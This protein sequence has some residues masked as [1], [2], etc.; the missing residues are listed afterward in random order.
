MEWQNK[1]KPTDRTLDEKVY[2]ILPQADVFL[3]MQE[4]ESTLDSLVQRKRL[5]LQ[6]MIGRSM[7]ISKTL[8]I[9]VSSQVRNQSWQQTEREPGWTLR[10]EG[11]LL[12][13][14]QCDGK[15]RAFS[16][17]VTSVVVDLH[18]ETGDE[19]VEWHE[20]RLPPEQHVEFDGLDVARPG[21][22]KVH[23]KVQIQLKEYPDLF[24]LS[25]QLADIL[26]TTEESKPA[27]VVSLW[28]YIRYHQLQDVDEKRV[29][30]C[31]APLQA[32]FKRDK[33]VLPQ[34]VE[35]LG[36]HLS[37]RE[38][39][40]IEYDIDPT[41]DLSNR[42]L[43]FDV[44]IQVDHALRSELLAMLN[45]WPQCSAMIAHNDNGIVQ[46]VQTLNMLAYQ[47][48]FYREFCENPVE[49]INNWVASQAA[50]LKA[51]YSDR[52]FSEEAVRHSSFYT[53]DLIN[54]ALHLFLGKN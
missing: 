31:N 11:R 12:N 42:D 38:P 25:P 6:D 15:P 20:A 16:S 7:R 4:V 21:T 44:P 49:F 14:D 29:I 28:H 23:A 26:G 40:T 24:K 43:A 46:E 54:P 35:L 33:I 13:D 30:R 53:D 17:M 41:Q 47:H 10:V 50:D 8:R 36:P 5:D 51:I 9:F 34:L 32:L 52:Q 1:R 45:S 22:G 37:P 18:S 48:D 27:V 2:D 3:R 39:V 19:V